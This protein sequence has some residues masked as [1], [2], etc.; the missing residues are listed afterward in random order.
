MQTLVPAADGVPET[1]VPG[2][3]AGHA[4]NVRQDSPD[5]LVGDL[6][7]ADATAIVGKALAAL[8]GTSQDVMA[9]V[10]PLLPAS[11]TLTQHDGAPT[12]RLALD[13]IQPTGE[14]LRPRLPLPS[15]RRRTASPTARDGTGLV[16]TASVPASGPA[17]PSLPADVA[18]GL[19][20]ITIDALTAS[21]DSGFLAELAAEMNLP[22]NYGR[23]LSA[24]LA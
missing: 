2:I 1:A 22:A 20:P 16:P 6:A 15:R 17:V 14:E 8:N 4:V 5:P 18:D 12:W 11:L 19:T 10:E 24:L 21:T 3:P 13:E 7:L 23:E 9:A